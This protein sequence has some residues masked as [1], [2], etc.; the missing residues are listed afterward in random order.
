[1]R[2]GRERVGGKGKNELLGR[3]SVDFSIGEGGRVKG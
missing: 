2:L 1:V 3:R